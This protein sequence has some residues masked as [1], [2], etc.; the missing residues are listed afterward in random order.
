MRETQSNQPKTGGTDSTDD[1][2][3][4]SL[5]DELRDEQEPADDPDTTG[6]ESTAPNDVEQDHDG[7]RPKHPSEDLGARLT[8]NL[9]TPIGV[10][11]SSMFKRAAAI[12]EMQLGEENVIEKNRHWYPLIF[13]LGLD[14]I[15]DMNDE[16]LTAALLAYDDEHD[17]E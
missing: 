3:L 6:Q 11:A 9:Y 5:S 1:S 7:P 17:Y 4:G 10:R 13:E 16:E 15:E 12:T 14:A 8:V 2:P